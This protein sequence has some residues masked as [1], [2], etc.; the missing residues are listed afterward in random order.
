MLFRRSRACNYLAHAFL[1]I[2]FGVCAGIVVVVIVIL[3]RIVIVIV[4]VIVVIVVVIVAT[5][6]GNIFI[7]IFIIMGD[8]RWQHRK[9]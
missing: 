5:S 2:L 8:E 3:V 9:E 7:G 1:P 6:T 4:L